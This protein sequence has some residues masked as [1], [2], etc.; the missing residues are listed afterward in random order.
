MRT[1]R[2]SRVSLA[3]TWNRVYI[4]SVCVCYIR[5]RLTEKPFPHF[6]WACS[7]LRWLQGPWGR[8]VTQIEELEE[9]TVISSD[10]KMFAAY[11]LS[12]LDGT[13][14]WVS[15]WTLNPTG[16]VRYHCKARLPFR[17]FCELH[18]HNGLRR[19]FEF[20]TCTIY[21]GSI[22]SRRDR[23]TMIR[24]G[25]LALPLSRPLAKLWPGHLRSW[26]TLKVQRKFWE[27][28]E[29]AGFLPFHCF[30]CLEHGI[31]KIFFRLI[32][33]RSERSHRS[34]ISRPYR[35]VRDRGIKGSREKGLETSGTGE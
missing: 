19:P 8:G 35:W 1:A 2:I 10:E 9:A 12:G 6:L 24:E 22:L 28:A 31:T 7:C 32:K 5:R 17:R 21:P 23:D 11:S 34:R 3:Q 26:I 18:R 13:E 27:N 29:Y 4:L 15:C 14:G 16:D 20:I 30:S 25:Y 33:R